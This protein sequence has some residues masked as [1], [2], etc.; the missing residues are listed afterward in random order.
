MNERRDRRIRS[1]FRCRMCAS[2]TEHDVRSQFNVTAPR[3]S[4]NRSKLYRRPNR[5][6]NKIEAIP[7]TREPGP[8]ELLRANS[9]LALFL[10]P[11]FRGANLYRV[12]S[13]V[14]G[15]STTY[16]LSGTAKSVIIRHHPCLSLK[17]N[18]CGMENLFTSI[19]VGHFPSRPLSQLI[20]H[21]WCHF[22]ILPGIADAPSLASHP[23]CISSLSRHP[24]Q[25]PSMIRMHTI[26]MVIPCQPLMPDELKHPTARGRVG[27]ATHTNAA[28]MKNPGANRG[29]N[30]E[31][32][33]LIG[34]KRGRS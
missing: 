1:L 3:S 23:F 7:G 19:P 10:H 12:E 27:T 31:V 34:C 26:A 24:L 16:R 29:A 2:I 28:D 21:L 20:R 22:D 32:L 8:V 9:G 15:N 5:W 4:G 18:W 6:R 25:R 30:Q 14:I 13:L 11:N 17:R 33:C